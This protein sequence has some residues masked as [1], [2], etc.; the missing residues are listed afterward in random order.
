M[1]SGS[2]NGPGS[3][4]GGG[5]GNKKGNYR[6][7]RR[8]RRPGGQGGKG[9]RGN[10]NASAQA[11][12]MSTST[13]VANGEP[14]EAWGVLETLPEGYGFLRTQKANYL[15]RPDDVWV[16]PDIIRDRRL[17][18]GVEI[19]GQ[20]R[21]T[22]RRGAALFE[23]HEINGRD[24]EAWKSRRHFADLTATSP[25]EP[26]RLETGPEPIETRVV[27]LVAPIGKGQRCL[28]VA[29]PKAGK[30]TLLQQIAHAVGVNHPEIHLIVLLV[31][32]R[33][34]EVT[35]WRR[36]VPAGEVI[37]SS[38]DELS[39]NH[40]SVA[41]IV[42]ERAKRLVETGSDVLILLD[43]LTRLA[44]AYN[45]EQ[46]GSGRILTGGIDSRTLENPRRFFGA[47]RRCEEGG[48]L[49][50]IASCLVDTGSKMDEVIFQDFKG[51]GNTEVVLDRSLFEKR[52]FP[53]I[54]IH[55]TG[56]RK[57]E[58]L[59]KAWTP[60]VHLLRRALASMGTVDAVEAL[61]KKL[62]AFESNEAFL[63]NLGTR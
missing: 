43:S 58:K 29:P 3:G 14:V 33:P 53:C 18:E 21:A 17:E 13:A 8:R 54:D 15:P 47:A 56:T 39:R 61:L 55:M 37:A 5:S 26:I 27:D 4:S 52:V 10:R 6:R 51:T 49:T 31:D 50:I 41:E 34:E 59:L 44:R 62:S 35:D 19:K 42:L 45:V 23:I 46:R 63:A 57:E 36:R 1:A 60:K 7:R 2:G 48:S 9:N 38:S 11:P 30:T 32:E 28:V 25:E 12:A 40:V 22:G 24:P 20:A 16:A